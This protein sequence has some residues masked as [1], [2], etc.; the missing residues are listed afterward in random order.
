MRIFCENAGTLKEKTD[1]VSAQVEG[2][3]PPQWAASLIRR[4]IMKRKDF[5]T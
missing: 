2:W 3:L 5:I 4:A 1:D